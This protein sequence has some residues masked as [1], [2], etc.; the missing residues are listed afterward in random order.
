MVSAKREEGG[1]HYMARLAAG[2]SYILIELHHVVC[3]GTRR[4]AVWGVGNREER[5][6]ICMHIT[7]I[8]SAF[9]ALS[10]PVDV[11]HNNSVCKSPPV[12]ADALNWL[13]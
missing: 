3:C 5:Y 11:T 10:A 4:S 8:L 9:A 2:S 7:T 12:P 13:Q 6:P 1:R